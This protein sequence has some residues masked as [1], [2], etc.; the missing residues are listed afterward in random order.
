[1]RA[2]AAQPLGA[3]RHLAAIGPIHRRVATRG[4]LARSG[5]RLWRFQ[6]C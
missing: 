5:I 1:M 6:E 3:R 2:A 4:L